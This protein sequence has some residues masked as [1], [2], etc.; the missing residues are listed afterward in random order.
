MAIQSSAWYVNF[1]RDD[2]VNVYGHLLS[3]ARAE[4]EVAFAA[5]ALELTPNARL[6]D[7]CCGPGRHSIV[8]AKRG[9]QVTALDLNSDYLVLT[10]RNA[11]EANVD[12]E[13]INA[14]MREIPFENHFDGVVNMFSSFG[15]LES[16]AEDARV[17]Q[18]VAKSCKRGGRL[19]LDMLNREWA[20]INYIQNDWHTGDDGTLYIERRDLDLATSRMHVRFTIVSPSGDRRDSVGH[21]IRLY[22][23][24][25]TTNLLEGA[26]LRI[27]AVYGGFD[28]EPYTIDS[29]RMIICAEKSR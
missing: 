17:L 27:S 18:A 6:L 21:N 1:F 22:T 24:T 15:Y 12:I 4:K 5:N 25:E 28:G 26:G 16:E 14:D 23:L 7:L 10:R 3:D 11:Q 19:L 20:V 9:F 13:T 8:L 2:Y 29:R